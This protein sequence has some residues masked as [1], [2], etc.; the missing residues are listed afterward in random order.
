M[1]RRASAPYGGDPIM[2]LTR[3][4]TLR[5]VA[6]AALAAA[7]V[8]LVAPSAHADGATGSPNAT[9]SPSSIAVGGT[10]T[11]NITGCGTKAATATS[12]AFG[13]VALQ[14]T[15]A[16]ATHL[17]GTAVI[18]QNATTGSHPVNFSCGPG[19]SRTVTVSLSVVPGGVRGGLGGSVER[20]STTE[21]VIGGTLVASALGGG[22][23]LLRRRASHRAS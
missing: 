17:S 7:P 1:T 13:A 16:Q 3:P 21:L 6:A 19:N 10:V 15:N 11:L 5:L 20:L 9:V 8:A 2:R 14:P 4:S 18:N 23:W 22:F 12:T